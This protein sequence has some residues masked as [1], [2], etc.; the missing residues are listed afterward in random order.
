MFHYNGGLFFGRR[1]DGS[2]RVLKINET[3]APFRGT[4]PWPQ[5]DGPRREDAR[6]DVTITADGWASIVASVSKLGEADG[7]FYKAQ[8]FHNEA[9]ARAPS[10]T[11]R[12]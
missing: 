2:V 12:G 3:G 6:L 11:E 4:E 5:A 1:A 10:G 8:H 7:R 9:V